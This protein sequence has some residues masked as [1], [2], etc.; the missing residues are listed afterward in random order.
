MRLP[1]NQNL[2]LLMGL[3]ASV[4]KEVII[5]RRR[6]I[7]V[8]RDALGDN[9]CWLDDYLVWAMLDDSPDSPTVVSPFETAMQL[10]RQFYIWRR[11][12][13]ADPVSADAI[14]DPNLWDKDLD[15]MSNA[16]LFEE[17][18]RIQ[19]VIRQHRDI[20]GRLRT[21]EDDRALYT[22]LP[23]KVSADFRLPAE[24]DFLGEAKAPLAGCPAFW[25][26]HQGCPA[27]C[28]NLH[29]WGPCLEKTR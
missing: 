18:A 21:V 4:L 22:V 12:E 27:P 2:L 19:N 6:V 13:I 9:R 16:D 20:N 7:R 5:E 29:Q 3:N 15:Q 1:Y 14:L 25:R 28:H 8:H 17:L 23:E 26:S 10:C 24:P 11:A